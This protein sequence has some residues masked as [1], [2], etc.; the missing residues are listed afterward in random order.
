[1]T[2]QVQLNCRYLQHCI[3]V[4]QRSI[5]S[6]QSVLHANQLL[7]QRRNSARYVATLLL[8]R[9]LL[10]RNRIPGLILFP[11]VPDLTAQLDWAA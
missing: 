7:L 6:V 3:R 1:M 4:F 11:N 8:Q 2:Q 5:N 9:A 10:C